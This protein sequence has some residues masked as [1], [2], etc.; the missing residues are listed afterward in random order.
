ME[1]FWP[2]GLLDLVQALGDQEAPDAVAR[3]E[4]E[5]ALEEVEAPE[6][7]ELVEHQ[8]QLLP[9]AIGSRSSV[10][11]RPIWLRIRRISGLV[12]LMSEG[13]TTRYRVIGLLALD[14]SR[15]RQSQRRVTSA[16]TGS[17]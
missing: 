5:R 11:R 8:E 15:I 16:T 17:R 13:G 1:L 12:R 4:R 9:A 3:H 6:R 10:S 7:R 14:Q 2:I